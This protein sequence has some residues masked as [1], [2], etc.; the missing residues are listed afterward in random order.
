VY[1]LK[2]SVYHKSAASQPYSS[3]PIAMW[4]HSRRLRKLVVARSFTLSVL[5]L[6][7]VY[8]ITLTF[9]RFSRSAKN[10]IV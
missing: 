5:F 1:I 7:L 10:S 8:V 3:S 9:V 6:C 2:Q 4:R